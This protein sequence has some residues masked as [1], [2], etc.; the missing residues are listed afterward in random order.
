MQQVIDCSM[1]IV[2]PITLLAAQAMGAKV[3]HT[4]VEARV[5][6]YRGE[7]LNVD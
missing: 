4:T 3:I 2:M 6:V 1:A 7:T 5:G